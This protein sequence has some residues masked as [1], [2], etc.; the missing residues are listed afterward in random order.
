MR[1]PQPPE[2][3]R[4]EYVG[5]LLTDRDLKPG[6]SF[7]KVLGDKL[8]GEDPAHSMLSPYAVCTDGDTRIFVADSNAQL[9]HVFDLDTR[10]Y[11]R[12]MPDAD[13][14]PLAQPMGIG[15]DPTWHPG[16]RLL[17][18]DG[19]GGRVVVFDAEGKVTGTIGDDLVQRP[20]GI[21]VDPATGRIF[22][23][24]ATAHQVAVF[25]AD[26]TLRRRLGRR[27][28]RPGEFNYPTNLV[29][30]AAGRLYVSDSMNFRVQVFDADLNPVRQIGS[31]GDLPG[32][33]SQPKGVALDTKGHLYVVDAH[34]EAVQIFD[35]QGDVLLTFGREGREA[36][37]FWLPAGIHIDS[38]DRIWVADAY[39]RRVQVFQFLAE[40]E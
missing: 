20:C 3:A 30:D 35:D 15:W 24:D 6:K 39:N 9:V 16:G 26:G 19:A 33:F 34:F 38:Q 27:G 8:F 12:W 31:Q 11:H 25:D 1:W 4:I 7:G 28:V 37:E 32:Y 21:A 22:V 2:P 10:A 29:L 13:G 14:P 18:A 17:V 40:A 5:Q 36:G 23:A